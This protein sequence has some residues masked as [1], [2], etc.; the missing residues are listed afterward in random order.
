MISDKTVNIA[1][2]AKVKGPISADIVLVSGDVKGAIE[3][4]SKINILSTGS[5]SGSITTSTLIVE[6]GAK[7]NGK[8]SMTTEKKEVESGAKMSEEKKEINE[9]ISSSIDEPEV[10]LE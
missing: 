8:S 6:P 9:S 1:K 10:E 4:K 2:S 5:I 7:L 3:A